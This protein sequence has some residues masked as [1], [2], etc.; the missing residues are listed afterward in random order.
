MA[1][2]ILLGMFGAYCFRAARDAEG[3]P[4]AQWFHALLGYDQLKTRLANSLSPVA[5]LQILGWLSLAFAARALWAAW[6]V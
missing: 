5:K 4:G 2:A 1:T 6:S 3:T